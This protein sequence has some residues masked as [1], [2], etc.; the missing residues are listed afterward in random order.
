M[1]KDSEITTRYE[2]ALNVFPGA[3]HSQLDALFTVMH[4]SNTQYVAKIQT[5][6]TNKKL[7]DAYFTT[8]RGRQGKVSVE[9]WAL[10]DTL[11]KTER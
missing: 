4:K 5:T 6:K 8:N 10:I 11:K 2:P 1:R 9:A 3:T 7:C